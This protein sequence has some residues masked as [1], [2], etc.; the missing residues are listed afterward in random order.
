MLCLFKGNKSAVEEH[1]VDD[2]LVKTTFMKAKAAS[3]KKEVAKELDIEKRIRDL[4]PQCLVTRRSED[5]KEDLHKSLNLLRT[6]SQDAT[7]EATTNHFAVWEAL[8]K[9]VAKVPNVII[10]QSAMKEIRKYQ[11]VLQKMEGPPNSRIGHEKILCDLNQDLVVSGI[12]LMSKRQ[13]LSS[14]RAS[15]GDAIQISTYRLEEHF[16]ENP[17]GS[18]QDDDILK[19]YMATMMKHFVLQ[20]KLLMCNQLNDHLRVAVRDGARHSEDFVQLLQE[21]QKVSHI[22][23]NSVQELQQDV[24]QLLLINKCLNTGKFSA[25]RLMQE[26]KSQKQFADKTHAGKIDSSIPSSS[27]ELKMLLAIPIKNFYNGKPS[28]NQPSEYHIM[29]S[30]RSL[31]FMFD[32]SGYGDFS[33]ILDHLKMIANQYTNLRDLSAQNSSFRLIFQP[34]SEANDL[35]HKLAQNNEKIYEILN[36]ILKTQITSNCLLQEFQKLFS[37][38]LENP[39]KKFVSEGKKFDGKSFK[40]Y[41]KEFNLYFRMIQK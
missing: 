12:E 14:L 39:L 2:Q 35:E 28:F 8:K 15:C 18:F 19:E 30:M 23:E 20:E 7:A 6:F 9:Y 3:L 32:R 5:V 34:T 26:L 40:M 36:A 4:M 24:A 27:E 33:T 11:S 22:I 41:E 31:G 16:A 29:R 10:F 37:F 38:S 25:I 17:D 1:S 21:S 13:N